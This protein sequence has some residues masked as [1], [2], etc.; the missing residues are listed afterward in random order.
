[1]N[2]SLARLHITLDE[3]GDILR[4]LPERTIFQSPEWLTFVARSQ[5]G[6]IVLAALQCEGQTVGYFAGVLV[7]RMGLKL[8]GSPL[9]G[10][11]TSY[12]GF[13]VIGTVS[14]RA[15]VDALIRFAFDDLHCLHVEMMDRNLAVEEIQASGLTHQFLSGFEVDLTQ[16]EERLFAN[17]SSACRR[18]IRKAEASGVSIHEANDLRFADDFYA[19]LQDVFKKQH[20]VPTYP[21]DRVRELINC[22]GGTGRLLLL[23]AHDSQGQCIATGI[24]PAMNETMY[25]WGG[26]SWQATQGYRPNEALHWYAMRYW[27][28]RGMKFYDMGG[29][30]DYKRKFGGREIKVPWVRASK[31]PGVPFVRGLAKH[32]FSWRQR[33]LGMVNG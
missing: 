19:Q 23:R 8:L 21:V 12:M 1:M 18:C 2:L 17:M 31:Y 28:A 15:A 27:K 22:V 29:G 25:F 32:L 33:A 5:E 3:W 26:A 30:G 13:N 4:G 20:L 11:T 24:F 10:W 16:S 14:R 7:T 9:P 6:E